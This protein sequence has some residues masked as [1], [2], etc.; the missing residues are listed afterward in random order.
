MQ[1]FS[2][3]WFCDH[4]NVSHILPDYNNGVQMGDHIFGNRV[5]NDYA[6]VQSDCVGLRSTA[7]DCVG[8]REHE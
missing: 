8:L 2:I 1:P 3:I 7:Q 4:A 5:Y 6:E